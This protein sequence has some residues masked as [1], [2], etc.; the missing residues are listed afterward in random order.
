MFKVEAEGFTAVDET[1]NEATSLLV[2]GEASPNAATFS[3][4]S[5]P[6]HWVALPTAP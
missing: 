5:L 6:C 3:E 4:R 2:Q 1:G